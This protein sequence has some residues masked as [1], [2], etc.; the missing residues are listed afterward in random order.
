M[1]RVGYSYN[2]RC[3]GKIVEDKA[4]ENG[5]SVYVY[6]KDQKI[7]YRE[8]NQNSGRMAKGYSQLGVKKGEA[9]SIMMPN[10]PEF[11]YHW[12]GLAKIGAIDNPINV[13]YKGDVLRHLIVNSKSKIVVIHEQFLEQ[14]QF[15]QHELKGVERII[16]YPRKKHGLRLEI[17]S[18][19]FDDVFNNTGEFFASDA[20]RPS[21]PLQIIYTG[22]TTGPSKGAVL[23]HNCVY[24]YT[25]DLIK[26]LHLT[27]KTRAYN[28]LPLFHQNHR[29]TSTYTLLLNASY[30]MGERYSARSFWDEVR[31]YK[32]THFHFLGGM[33]LIIYN[34][35][36]KPNDADNPAK[37]AWGGPIPLDIAES[38]EKR[39]GVKLYCGFYGLSEASGVSWITAEEADEL[40]AKGK[41]A[42]AVGMGRE[43]K[44][45][46]EVKL[47]NDEDQEVA[48]GEAGEIICR[49]ARA[50]AMM[51]EYVNN[52]KAT[53]EA[54]RNLWFHTGD[55]ARKDEDGYFHFVDRKKDY[56][57][58]RGENISSFEIEKVVN[59]HAS[60]VDSA[61]VGVKSEVGEDEVRIFVLVKEGSR[62]TPEEL[63]VWCEPRMAY[64]MIPRYVDFVSEFPRNPVGRIE[65]FKLRDIE[66]TVET[67]DRERAG[68]KIK[69]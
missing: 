60:V 13:S 68:Y 54:F 31:K 44:D 43:Q 5:E 15:I 30:A 38:F 51:T 9:I 7:T 50:Y 33:P 61:A 36:P 57:R 29:F 24:H 34:Q 65:K 62:L 20:V 28:C 17:P 32:A 48:D 64:F 6:F 2:Q 23:S 18:L 35:P 22:G 63:M 56:I 46:Y 14:I 39:F 42:Q 45:I 41:W 12:F 67:W 1:D 27:R 59:A 49:P 55:M 47:V 69:R 19:S 26:F 10:C 58:R 21:D 25:N 16:V 66:M 3:W 52:P 11:L 53:A 37:T 4:N 8:L 40:K